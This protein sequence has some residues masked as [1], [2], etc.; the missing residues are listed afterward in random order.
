M[1]DRRGEFGRN[2]RVDQNDDIEQHQE[3]EDDDQDVIDLVEYDALLRDHADDAPAGVADR[4]NDDRAG[5]PVEFFHMSAVVVGRGDQVVLLRQ[6]RSDQLLLWMIDEL[7]V[8]VHQIQIAPVCERHVIEQ[9]RQAAVFQVDE[10]YAAHRALP[11][12][13]LHRGGKRDHADVA[14]LR[15]DEQ[16]LNFQR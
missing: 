14:M 12:R 2:K 4:A 6:P 7:A 9:L 3:D 16:I 5:F 10:Q 1:F 11:A 13:D 15:V 8:C